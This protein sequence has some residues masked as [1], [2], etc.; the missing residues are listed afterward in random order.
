MFGGAVP[1]APEDASGGVCEQVDGPAR[2]ENGGR[3]AQEQR[4]LGDVEV[5]PLDMDSLAATARH[6]LTIALDPA[7]VVAMPDRFTRGQGTIE[8]HGASGHAAAEAEAE[9]FRGLED[10]ER[11][12]GAPRASANCR[13]QGF[14]SLLKGSQPAQSARTATEHKRLL[15]FQTSSIQF[16]VDTLGNSNHTFPVATQLPA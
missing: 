3:I 7:L 16:G 1:D 9:S 11:I 6:F 15:C 5:V 8:V 2:A 14:S 4:G 12:D 10:D 13:C